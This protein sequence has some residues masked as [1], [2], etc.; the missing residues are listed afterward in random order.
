MLLAVSSLAIVAPAAADGSRMRRPRGDRPEDAPRERGDRRDRRA[1]GE[2]PVDAPRMR[3]GMYGDEAGAYGEVAGVYGDMDMEMEMGME[4]TTTLLDAVAATPDLSTLGAAVD[5]AGLEGALS[6]VS[7]ALTVLAPTD[8]AFGDIDADTLTDLL[9]KPEEL[10]QIL[11]LHV[12]EGA[13]FAGDLTDGMVVPTL[14]GGELTVSVTDDGITFTSEGGVVSTVV[15]ADID[16]CSSVVH[17]I[18]SVLLP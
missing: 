9:G 12:I 16:V 18:D 2:R 13:V 10:A 8:D 11:T 15:M 14:S 1:R 6:D 5:A 17:V 3:E 7:T 4:C